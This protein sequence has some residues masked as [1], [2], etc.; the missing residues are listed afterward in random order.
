MSNE[1]ATIPA[2]LPMPQGIEGMDGRSWRVLCESIFP[3]A[4]TAEAVMMA[5]DY[6]RVRKL[7]PFKRPVNIVSMY[8][9]ALKKKVETVWPGINSIQ[10]DASRTKE[11]AGMDDAVWG[12]DVTETFIGEGNRQDEEGGDWVKGKIEAT[13]T[14]PKSCSVTVY[15]MVDGQKCA[16]TETVFWKEAYGKISGKIDVPNSMW[17]KRPYGQL[18]KC[19]KAAVLR[20]AFPEEGDYTS[21]EMEGKEIESGGVVI[22][23]VTSKSAYG[24]AT[25]MKARWKEIMDKITS[26]NSGEA[27]DA[28]FKQ[29]AVD[30]KTMHS[31]DA[32][33]YDSLVNAGV[34][35]RNAIASTDGPEE[36]NYDPNGEFDMP[37][38]EKE[39]TPGFLKKGFKRSEPEDYIGA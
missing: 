34:Q 12:P 26:S 1:L 39:E 9:S 20:A 25:A 28:V 5:L 2:R 35:R 29:Y 11:W 15:R 33:L 3:S 32:Q 36:E 17:Q 7:D 13:V 24:S 30:F 4:K 21:D 37:P 31:I 16:F 19:A 38:I 8:N 18:H 27:L 10:I 14:Y 23:Q 22:E 6:C